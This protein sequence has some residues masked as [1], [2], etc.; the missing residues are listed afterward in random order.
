MKE[1]GFPLT[2]STDPAVRTSAHNWLHTIALLEGV[3]GLAA[4]AASLGLLSLAHHDL[5]ALAF[6]FI[7]H[8]HLDPDAHYPRWLLDEATWLQHADV[9]QVVLYASAYATLRFIEGYGL[10][11]D[12]TWAEWLAAG[13]GGIYLPI[14][15][16]HWLQRASWINASVLALN[17]LIV[18]YMVLR[19]W[20]KKTA[21]PRP[22][23]EPSSAQ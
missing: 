2:L 13:S 19:L 1:R 11:K 10:W 21:P 22:G 9:R 14:E 23:A 7:G 5:R 17:A 6:A 12:R 15:I 8:W 20:R 18:L 16:Q 4:V 3:K